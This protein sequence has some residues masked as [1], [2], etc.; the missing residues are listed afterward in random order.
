MYLAKIIERHTGVP[1]VSSNALQHAF[2]TFMESANEVEQILLHES[3][4]YA[5]RHRIK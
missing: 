3:T 5:M 4:A 1:N 2:T